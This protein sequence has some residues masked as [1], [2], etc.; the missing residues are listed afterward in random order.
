MR[1]L[2][3]EVAE[4]NLSGCAERVSTGLTKTS[5]G[6]SKLR[7]PSLPGDTVPIALTRSGGF[8]VAAYHKRAGLSYECSI[9]PVQARGG[10]CVWADRA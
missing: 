1:S 4:G 7:W 10:L 3:A 2:R 5:S 8:W 6:L 9:S